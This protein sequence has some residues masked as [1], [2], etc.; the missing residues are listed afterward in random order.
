MRD[1][2]IREAKNAL[3]RLI[4]SVESGKAVRITR[5]GKPVAV[6]L[7]SREYQRLSAVVGRRDPWEFL[8]RWRAQLPEDFE[9]ISDRDVDSW[10]DKQT[11]GGRGTSWS[12]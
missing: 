6:L 7:S 10:R 1:S 2:T 4:R 9:G 12:G 11:G 8:Q 5:H 3:T